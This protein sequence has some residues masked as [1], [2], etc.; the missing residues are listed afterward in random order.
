MTRILIVD[1]D[2]FGCDSLS[3][4]LSLEGFDIKVAFDGPT[5]IEIA[6]EFLPE[7][8][9]A[10][11]MLKSELDGIQV[12]EILK[13]CDPKIQTIVITGRA[14]AELLARIEDDPSMRLVEKPTRPEEIIETVREAGQRRG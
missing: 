9:I 7:V 3:V 2:R 12:A 1:D 11:F 6:K 10:D 8:L 4:L 13:Q 5:A 14:S